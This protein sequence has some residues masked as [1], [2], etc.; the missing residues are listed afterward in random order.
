[1]S[2]RT[3]GALRIESRPKRVA[4]QR[5]NDGRT[6]PRPNLLIAQAY[7]LRRSEGSQDALSKRK[8]PA[9]GKGRTRALQ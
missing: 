7:H 1:M 5:D 2:T 8:R 3:V 6:S 9:K 4:R